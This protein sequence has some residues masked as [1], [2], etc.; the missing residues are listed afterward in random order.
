MTVGYFVVVRCK[1]VAGVV[2]RSCATAGARRG[3]EAAASTYVFLWASMPIER[4]WAWT[5]VGRAWAV[6]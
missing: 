2:A 6:A 3:G 4:L 5:A 1:L